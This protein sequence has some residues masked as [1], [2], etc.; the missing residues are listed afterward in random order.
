[1]HGL[2]ILAGC[3][4]VSAASVALWLQSRRIDRRLFAGVIAL[5]VTT[6]LFSVI[7]WAATAVAR[8]AP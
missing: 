5:A 3:L 4:G 7:A 1:V 6:S 8:I 2:L